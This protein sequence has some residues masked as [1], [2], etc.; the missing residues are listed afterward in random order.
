MRCAETGPDADKMA[1]AA[2]AA[3]SLAGRQPGEVEEEGTAPQQAVTHQ[4]P[5]HRILEVAQRVAGI[6]AAVVRLC[7]AGRAVVWANYR[8]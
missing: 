7:A 6:A 1:A 3:H 8:T 4:I 2:A 5:A